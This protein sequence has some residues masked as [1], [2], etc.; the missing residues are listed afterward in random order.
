M[1]LQCGQR[2]KTI[3]TLGALDRVDLGVKMLLYVFLEHLAIAN[4][5]GGALGT[6]LTLVP[7]GKGRCLACLEKSKLDIF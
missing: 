6:L 7:L 1:L 5:K 4:A 2:A 3:S